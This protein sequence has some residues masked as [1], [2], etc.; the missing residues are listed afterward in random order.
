MQIDE[1]EKFS[2][3]TRNV[4]RIS[5]KFK[6]LFSNLNSISAGPMNGKLKCELDSASKISK[7]IKMKVKLNASKREE[8]LTENYLNLLK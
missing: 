5:E 7:L 2:S 4:E 1:L 3:E 8:I 6:T